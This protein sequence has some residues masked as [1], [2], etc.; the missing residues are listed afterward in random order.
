MEESL[1]RLGLARGGLTT[2]DWSDQTFGKFH[3]SKIRH[4]RIHI[5]NKHSNIILT[6]ITECDRI[7][8]KHIIITILGGFANGYIKLN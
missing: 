6:A 4:N 8:S 1:A 7:F 3:W 5:H 2:R